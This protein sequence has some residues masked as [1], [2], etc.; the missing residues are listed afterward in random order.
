MAGD[1]LVVKSA[2]LTGMSF[3]YLCAFSSIYVQIPGKFRFR[4]SLMSS[5]FRSIRKGNTTYWNLNRNV[6]VKSSKN[7]LYVDIGLIFYPKPYIC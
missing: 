7:E 3:I 6:G 5:L 1:N 2:F 4:Y